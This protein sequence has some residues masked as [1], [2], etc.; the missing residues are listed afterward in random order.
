MG[1]RGTPCHLSETKAHVV[2]LAGLRSLRDGL[3]AA[4]PS[5]LGGLQGPP[6]LGL[7]AACPSGQGGGFR[8]C[9]GALQGLPFLFVQPARASCHG[10]RSCWASV[11]LARPPVPVKRRTRAPNQGPRW[12]KGPACAMAG[13]LRPLSLQWDASPPFVG[14]LT[15]VPG[16]IESQNRS[17]HHQEGK[18][19]AL[20]QEVETRT[21][22][23]LSTPCLLQH[24]FQGAMDGLDSS[25]FPTGSAFERAFSRLPCTGI[26]MA[27]LSG[28]NVRPW[29]QKSAPTGQGAEARR[30]RDDGA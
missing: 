21:G 14:G 2:L 20:R 10:L 3:W 7:G 19:G 16:G 4:F 25:R 22:K 12:K 30:R 5:C 27:P 6:C 23:P 17:L 1:G 8:S 29:R 9:F 18:R 11:P 24:A 15:H 26:N 28:G 13:P